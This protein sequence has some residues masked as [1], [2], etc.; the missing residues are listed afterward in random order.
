VSEYSAEPLRV[1]VL[2]GPIG[3]VYMVDRYL[4][5]RFIHPRCFWR[6]DEGRLAVGRPPFTRRGH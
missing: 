6:G 4:S 1:P 3:L 5:L 2:G